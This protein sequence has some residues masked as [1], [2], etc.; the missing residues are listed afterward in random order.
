MLC[1]GPEVERFFYFFFSFFSTAALSISALGLISSFCPPCRTNKRK[2]VVLP[3]L[4]IRG[5]PRR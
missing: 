2:H 3:G 4:R 5:W 1:S